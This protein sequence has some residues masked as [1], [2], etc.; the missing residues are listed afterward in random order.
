MP[1]ITA[2]NIYPLKS[3]RGLAMTEATLAD[4][5]LA[6]DR[7]WM[8]VDKTGMFVTQREFPKLALVTPSLTPSGLTVE[9]PS[10]S[11]LAVDSSGDRLD[12]VLF[13]ETCSA[14]RTS[15]EADEWFSTYLGA[16]VSL[17]A[18]DPRFHRRGGVQY[19]SRD[20]RAT[21]FVDNYGILIISQA[22]LDDLNTRLPSTVPMNR[23]R[24]NIVV[25]GMGPFE[26]EYVR[27]F[28]I[29]DVELSATNVCTRCNLTTINQETAEVGSEPFQTLSQYRYDEGYKGVRFGAYAAVGAGVGSKLR[30]GDTV[31][32]ELDI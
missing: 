4:T 1:T 18:R 29:S 27:T 12:C 2:I 7:E 8:I 26:E 19:P 6:N 30:V 17:V 16:K 20:E 10:M 28:A 3:A 32:I 11:K 22:S 5:G 31:G 24:P 23:F 25:D 13:G 14:L 21:S 9:A 15:D